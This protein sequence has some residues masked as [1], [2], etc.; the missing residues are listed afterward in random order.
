MTEKKGKIRKEMN[1]HDNEMGAC[2]TEALLNY[3][4]VGFPI[5]YCLPSTCYLHEHISVLNRLPLYT[6]KPT[7]KCL[8]ISF[9][10]SSWSTF[11]KDCLHP[12]S[13]SN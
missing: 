3:E 6:L 4:T 12:S 9:L 11:M 10:R 8:F 13:I 5:L 1:E 7:S 2:F